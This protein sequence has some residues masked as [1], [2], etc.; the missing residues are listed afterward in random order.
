MVIEISQ[1]LIHNCLI[2][3]LVVKFW[4]Q[5]CLWAP[6][7][8]LRKALTF[9]FF[10]MLPNYFNCAHYFS[11]WSLEYAFCKLWRNV[12]I[13]TCACIWLRLAQSFQILLVNLNCLWITGDNMLFFFVIFKKTRHSYTLLFIQFKGPL[14]SQFFT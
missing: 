3:P 8:R 13:Y 14:G 9:L 2:Y 11:I 5:F 1:V 10:E 4:Q 7:C 12:A 6:L